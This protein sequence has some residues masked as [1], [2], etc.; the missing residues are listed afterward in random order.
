MKNS[1]NTPKRPLKRT[2]ITL[3]V[4]VFGVIIYAY[5]FQVTDVNFAE[6]REETRRTQLFR[7][8]RA[9]AQ[10][11]LFDF[12]QEE[13]RVEQDFYIPCNNQPI[14][15][16]E[17]ADGQPSITLSTFCGDEGAFVDITG[18][19]FYANTTVSVILFVPSSQVN[20]LLDGYRT[21]ADG[22]FSGQLQLPERSSEDAF[23][24]VVSASRNVGLPD[25][26][27]NALN[28][29][30]RIIE[31]VFLAFLATT[32]GTI[33]SIPLSF[34]AA[35]NIM[36]EIKSSLINI[37]L[38]LILAPIGLYIGSKFANLAL[39]LNNS[40]Q[41]SLPISIL[42]LL[43]APFIIFFVIK[44]SL[45]QEI[46]IKPG[47]KK[48]VL[49]LFF[50]IISSLLAVI[51]LYDLSALMMV[52]GTW[53][54]PQLGDLDFLGNFF[55]SL[56][57]LIQMMLGL[58]ITLIVGGI[59]G[60]I[61]NKVGQFI[62]QKSPDFIVKILHFVLAIAAGAIIAAIIGSA[63][64]WMYQI[65]NLTRT[66]IIPAIIG[67]SVGLLLAIFSHPRK[68]LALGLVTYYITRTI[69][70]GLRAIEA[71]IMAIVFVVWVGI[72]P[73][74][75]VLA[76]SLHTVAALSKLYSEQVESIITGPLEAVKATGANKLQ[77]ILYAVVPQIIPPY[78]S[79]TMYR[80]DIN[81]R[82]STIIGFAG[83]GGIGFLLFQNINLLNYR[84]ASLQ[85]IAIAVVVALMDY[86][87]SKMREK[88]I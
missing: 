50:I 4:I 64:D 52:F 38:M 36:G 58:I 79:F 83:G 44:G 73:F 59:F 72:G 5:G 45:P 23:Q 33:L 61:G 62:S 40:F 48:R 39:W 3:A 66:I 71:I 49:R 9:L 15:Q 81:V 25:L 76:L 6:T 67:G 30:E 55:T 16:T 77:T 56:G 46:E 78:I 21:D 11:D 63:I 34:L 22:S 87:S 14:T 69:F 18:A 86:L 31:T 80:W 51:W 41:H 43:I 8:L 68:Q 29:W 24:I 19:N 26:S 57:D 47:F 82:M 20:I 42:V 1:T 54:A 53:V 17:F 10:P 13:L 85:M 32:F 12:E 27:Q 2:L 65:N 84:G 7:I 70:N 35:R 75:G 28:T 88:V 60:S 74:A 37:S